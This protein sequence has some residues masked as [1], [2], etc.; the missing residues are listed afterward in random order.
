MQ[1]KRDLW[2]LP[3]KVVWLF[4]IKGHSLCTCLGFFPAS[5]SKLLTGVRWTDILTKWHRVAKRE[6]IRRARFLTP[7]CPDKHS[8]LIN[9]LLISFSSIWLCFS[10]GF[11]SSA[12][13]TRAVWYTFHLRK[14]LWEIGLMNNPDKR[15]CLPFI[16]SLNVKGS[17]LYYQNNRQVNFFVNLSSFLTSNILF[18]FSHFSLINWP[19]FIDIMAKSCNTSY[20]SHTSFVVSS[21]H[22]YL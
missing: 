2:T 15:R 8:T 21:V 13:Q 11:Y 20:F 16:H 7:S 18:I 5:R 17:W 9:L 10:S 19:E 14:C 6:E 12:K 3:N 1:G 4:E 22:F